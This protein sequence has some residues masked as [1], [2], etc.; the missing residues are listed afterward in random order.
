[1]FIYYFPLSLSRPNLEP[2]D[3]V[4]GSSAKQPS[5]VGSVCQDRWL[6]GIHEREHVNQNGCAEIVDIHTALV[7][8]AHVCLEHCGKNLLLYMF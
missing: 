8:L 3:F 4:F 1:M 5:C 6:T 2:V 7:S